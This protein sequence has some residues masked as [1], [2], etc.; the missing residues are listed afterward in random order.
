MLNAR[1]QKPV[2]IGNDADLAAFDMACRLRV[3][4]LVYLYCKDGLGIGVVNNGRT[5]AGASGFSPEI[6]HVPYGRLDEECGYCHHTDCLQTDVTRDGYLHKYLGH[7]VADEAER[8]AEWNAFIEAVR[9]EEPNALRVTDENAHILGQV[10]S[11]VAAVL[12]PETF[13]LGGMPQPLFDR[14]RPIIEEELNSR[15][16]HASPI[17]MRMDPDFQRTAALGAAETL[18]LR[19]SPD[20]DELMGDE[21]EERA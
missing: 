7:A 16:R 18:Y 10:C 12:R 11:L 5:L 1:I 3:N 17:E 13:V 19:W 8:H 20:L 21:E 9:R 4:Y 15:E 2:W 6:S 14:I